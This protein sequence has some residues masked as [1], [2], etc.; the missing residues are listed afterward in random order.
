MSD[1]VMVGRRLDAELIQIV[2]AFRRRRKWR[3]V[4]SMLLGGILLFAGSAIVA[5]HLTHHTLSNTP[6]IGAGAGLYAVGVPLFAWGAA[7]GFTRRLATWLPVTVVLGVLTVLVL[8]VAAMIATG[9]DQ[10][11][12]DH[13]GNPQG[14]SR[15][16]P[17]P[18]AQASTSAGSNRVLAAELLT[19]ADVARYLGPAPA[20]LQ[21]PGRHVART[22]SL[23]IWR[24]VPGQGSGRPSEQPALSLTVQ[25]SARQADKLSRGHFPGG[26][27]PV[28]G[29][30]GGY[31][32][33]HNRPGST[34]NVTRVRAGRGEWV[35]ALQLRTP[36][37]DDPTG[38]LA[39]TVA[40]L[41][42]LLNA[43]SAA[44]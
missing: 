37:A 3:H 5:A 19:Q 23:A 36:I 4:L 13:N 15:Y 38:L 2:R 40:Q 32:R 1:P 44:R 27:Q 24:S 22:R 26:A 35:V 33:H 43:A 16:R 25:H 7:A 29:L 6:A 17:T 14:N 34:G 11:I 21:T 30:P 10:I 18:P 28:Q 9:P 20:D 31:V 39:G 12:M 8:A 42:E 41:I